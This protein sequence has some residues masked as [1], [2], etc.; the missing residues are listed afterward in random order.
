MLK[1]LNRHA[2]TDF[3]VS[4]HALEQ[5]REKLSVQQLSLKEKKLPVILLIEGWGSAG[6][7]SLIGR[8]IRYLDRV[9]SRSA[10]GASLPTRNCANRFSGII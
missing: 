8:L 2:R 9:F 7:G 10:P 5:Y 6:K 1:N 3:V 4:D